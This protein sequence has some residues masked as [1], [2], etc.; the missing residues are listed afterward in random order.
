M[1]KM[2]RVRQRRQDKMDGQ[3]DQA[4][5]RLRVGIQVKFFRC[6]LFMFKLQIGCFD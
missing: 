4:E 2:Q 6:I 5:V 1:T 3:M